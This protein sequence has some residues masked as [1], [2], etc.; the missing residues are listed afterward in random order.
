[1]DPQTLTVDEVN[2]HVRLYLG[3]FAA[4]LVLTGVTVA[5][6]FV[7]LG[8]GFNIALALVIATLKA[9]L[10]GLFFMHLKWERKSV[11]GL[12]FLT[13]F[14]FASLIFSILQGYWD[15]PVGTLHDRVSV[16]IQANP[17]QSEERH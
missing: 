10:V 7:D 4:L 11:Y 8:H 9:S 2:R 16:E 5:V 15:T 3:V 1:M 12:I 17:I 6:A 14:F 13:F